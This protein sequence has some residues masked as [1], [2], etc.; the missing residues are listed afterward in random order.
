MDGKN[1][2]YRFHN[3]GLA[4]KPMFQVA[5]VK[6]SLQSL[7]QN[8]YS[9]HSLPPS[10]CWLLAARFQNQIVTHKF[11]ELRHIQFLMNNWLPLS[12]S[13]QIIKLLLTVFPINLYVNCAWHIAKELDFFF[14]LRRNLVPNFHSCWIWA[15]A[16]Q[17][18]WTEEHLFRKNTLRC[19][20]SWQ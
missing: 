4:W 20:A 12:L 5:Q 9:S 3:T 16:T 7:S 14:L 2:S 13:G 1:A 8:E 10:G 11:K 6:V 15:N 17:S 18:G 19:S